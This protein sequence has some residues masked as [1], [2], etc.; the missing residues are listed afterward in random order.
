VLVDQARRHLSGQLAVP[1]NITLIP[2][3]AKRPELNP[4]E[5]VKQF[6]RDSW[7]SNR[8]F[9]SFDDIVDHC[10][11]AATLPRC[12]AWNNLIDQPL[13][14]MSIAPRDWAYAS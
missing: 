6:M 12:H 3:P 14:I 7:L 2:L 8:I 4:Q 1:P 13:R 5:N 11:H 9:K 10:C